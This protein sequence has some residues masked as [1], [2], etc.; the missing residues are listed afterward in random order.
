MYITLLSFRIVTLFVLLPEYICMYLCCYCCTWT[1]R[2]SYVI[3]AVTTFFYARIY[4]IK[5]PGLVMVL[6]K[7]REKP[8]FFFFRSDLIDAIFDDDVLSLSLFLLP[9]R[10]YLLAKCI[11]DELWFD[12][13]RE[14][15]K[16]IA[17]TIGTSE[18]ALLHQNK[19]TA[20]RGEQGTSGEIIFFASTT[21]IT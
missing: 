4:V 5:R 21:S 12:K 10:F 16:I 2:S 8:L 9:V 18:A 19:M 17:Y 7:K 6:G 11:L 13:E 1:T 15:D 14:R 3:T 20:G